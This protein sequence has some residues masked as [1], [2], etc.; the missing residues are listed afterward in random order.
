MAGLYFRQPTEEE[1]LEAGIDEPFTVL[2]KERTEEAAREHEKTTEQQA[3]EA[4][5]NMFKDSKYYLDK[6]MKGEWFA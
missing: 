3:Q 1:R 4:F 6:I 2:D 5:D